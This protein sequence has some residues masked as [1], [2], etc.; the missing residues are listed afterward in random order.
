[1]ILPNRPV[2]GIALDPSVEARNVPVGYAAVGGFNANTPSTPGHVLQVTCAAG[3]TPSPTASPECSSFK[4]EKKPGNNLPDSTP[5]PTPIPECSSFEWKNKTGNN[6]PDIPVYSIIV[7]PN[8]PKQVF[9]GT[10]WGVYFTDDITV[11]SP[12]WQRLVNGIP[13]VLVRDMQIDRFATTLSVWT[14]GRGA[15]VYPLPGAGSPTPTP[16]PAGTP[17][18]RPSP[19]AKPRPTAT[20]RP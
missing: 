18:P 4:W 11:A 2:L 9:I 7:N 3:P 19:T 8:I 10:V 20:P 6:L 15:Y 1:M 12:R 13:N 16:T 5:S 17:T 14:Y